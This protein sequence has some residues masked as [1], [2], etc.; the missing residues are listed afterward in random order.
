MT[1]SID[2]VRRVRARTGAGVVDCRNALAEAGGDEERAA[3]ILRE[4]GKL[5][6]AGRAA[7]AA[8]EGI[9]GA[10]VHGNAKVAALVSLT[11]ETDFVAR[12]EKFRALAK[13][14]AMHVVAMRP[15]AVRPEDVPDGGGEET[16]EARALLTQAF[17]RDERV[18]VGDLVAR[19]AAEFGENIVVAEFTRMELNGERSTGGAPP[20]RRS[21]P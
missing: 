7:R 18:T 10:Y 11:C 16:R 20:V 14:L 4:R 12:N 21:H 3:A 19:H 6:A 1:I 17:V 2:A 8:A 5:T 9:I 13:D 15:A